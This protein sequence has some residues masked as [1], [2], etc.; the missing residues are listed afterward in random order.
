MT[1]AET[2]PA[3]AAVP[4]GNAGPNINRGYTDDDDPNLLHRQLLVAVAAEH[5][6][7]HGASVLTALQQA[8]LPLVHFVMYLATLAHIYAPLEQALAKAAA[9]HPDVLG[10]IHFPRELNR[11]P[12]LRTDLA[13]FVGDANVDA[14]IALVATPA[15][16]EWRDR[17][18]SLAGAAE[19]KDGDQCAAHAAEEHH[20]AHRLMAH[21][22][23]RYLGDLSGGQILQS[24]IA[25]LYQLPK[26]DTTDGSDVY[27]GVRFY[28]FRN[29]ADPKYFKTMY[30]QTLNRMGD[31][32]GD[33]CR[34]E[35]CDEAK[36]SFD[37]NYRML[38][39]LADLA[40]AL[41][42]VPSPLIADGVPEEIKQVGFPAP[43]PTPAVAAAA[44]EPTAAATTV[45]ERTLPL[46][47]P[48]VS[49]PHAKCPLRA[50]PMVDPNVSAS[51]MALGFGF[52]GF[53]LGK[54]LK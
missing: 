43:T 31:E 41:D 17:M 54:A 13:Y 4:N 25:K 24:R 18:L 34:K 44:A 16:A 20:G 12:A 7:I 35:V 36:Y 23:T 53:A 40:K 19:V 10:Q 8:K 37:L 29:V 15:T 49:D 52:L 45:P 6:K 26:V 39:Q 46:G 38:E 50:L 32:L 42:A 3:Q 51:L 5:H 14:W 48:S 28:E 27:H 22:Y 21:S 11:L 47:H 33:A 1:T 9:D 30:R 2:L